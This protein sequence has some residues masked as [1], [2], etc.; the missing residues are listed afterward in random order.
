[1]SAIHLLGIAGVEP[2]EQPSAR[3]W[4]KRLEWPMVLVVL[5][6][7]FQWYLEETQTIA[8]QLARIADWLVWLAFLFETVLLSALV[9][10]RRTYLFGNWMNLVIITGGMPFFGKFLR[11]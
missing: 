11:W 9:K 6:I 8:P 1:M 4:A 10:H 7:P 2:H 3:L 5:W